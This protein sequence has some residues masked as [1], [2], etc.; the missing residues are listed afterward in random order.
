[1][2]ATGSSGFESIPLV[3]QSGRTVRLADFRGKVVVL[4]P[5][6]TL[7]ADDVPLT[8]GA[9]ELLQRWLLGAGLAGQVVLAEVSV[10]PQEDD[11]SMLAA[12]AR[13]VG[14]SWY[15]LSGKARALRALWKDFGV[16]YQVITETVPE[17]GNWLDGQPLTRDV[18]YTEGVFVLDRRGHKRFTA[19]GR[20]DPG[21]VLPPALASMLDEDGLDDLDSPSGSTWTPAGVLDDVSKLIG[22]G[23]KLGQGRNTLDQP[24]SNG[25]TGI[26]RGHPAT[27]YPTAPMAAWSRW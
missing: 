13:R 8:T 21:G 4:A 24:R 17:E 6:F 27:R 10:D 1:M 25:I 7:G 2:R 16:S 20:P 15:L 26:G 3:D 22:Q 11:P 9:F 18:N 12:Y 19:I 14:S 23:R 5:F